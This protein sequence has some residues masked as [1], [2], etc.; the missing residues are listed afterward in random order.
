MK[1][2]LV[3]VAGLTMLA[4]P[5]LAQDARPLR[6]GVYGGASLPQGDLDALDM[7]YIV[8]GRADFTPATLPIGL[9]FD[10]AYQNWGAE[11]GDGIGGIQV[12]GNALFNIPTT[13]G[14]SPYVMGGLGWYRFSADDES[15]S[16]IGFNLGGGINI[17]LGTLDAFAELRYHIV[18]VENVSFN[19]LPIVF[20]I[21][22]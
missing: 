10:A 16:G 6:F 12:L 20:G 13:G 8:G 5:A 18:E 1:R 17:N 15:E 3:A 9:R 22:F 14:I 4:A 11:V 21:R 19:H 2:L 7:G